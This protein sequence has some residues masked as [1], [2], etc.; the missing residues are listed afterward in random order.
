MTSNKHQI[1]T[2]IAFW[3]TLLLIAWAPLPLASNRPWSMALLAA[4]A[5]ILL[6]VMS[7]GSLAR[8]KETSSLHAGLRVPLGI[9]SFTLLWIVVQWSTWTPEMWHHPVWKQ[10]SE[11][12]GRELPGRITVNPD[13]TMASLMNLGTYLAVFWLAMRTMR[14]RD[15]A[16]RAL[17]IFVWIAAGYALYGLAIFLSGSE[18]ILF[19]DKWDYFDSVTSTFVNRNS[20]ATYAGLALVCALGLVLDDARRI[21]G[22]RGGPVVSEFTVAILR[23]NS[24]RIAAALLLA[25]ALILTGSRAGVASSF[26]GMFALAGIAATGNRGIGARGIVVAAPLLLALATAIWL[27]SEPLFERLKRNPMESDRLPAYALTVDAIE[28]SPLFGTGYGGF[29]ESFASNRDLAVASPS[30]WKKAHNTYLEN[31]LDL[32]IPAAL[33]LNLAILLV[34]LGALKAALTRRRSPLIPAIGAAA[35]VLVGLHALFDFSLQIP[36]VAVSYAFIMGAAAAQSFRRSDAAE[37]ETVTG[38]ASTGVR[39]DQ[40]SAHRPRDRVE[41]G[42]ADPAVSEVA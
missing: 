1:H 36:A 38:A 29:Q 31:M 25:A 42:E 2:Q 22:G 6:I 26:A 19:F 14:H 24:G 41:A 35:T 40:A 17:N 12:L 32:G 4:M 30:S 33:A 9:V 28:A 34:A 18:T 11:A 7:V 5:G 15:S 3:G 10:A 21:T 13:A 8:D 37:K 23:R 16:R 27:V 20:F 39:A